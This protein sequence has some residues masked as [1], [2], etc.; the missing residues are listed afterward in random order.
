MAAI[1]GKG[2][3]QG[4]FEIRLYAERNGKCYVI[5]REA[6]QTIHAHFEIFPE[7]IQLLDVSFSKLQNTEKVN[8]RIENTPEESHRIQKICHLNN[9]PSPVVISFSA[10][11]ASIE[12]PNI[13]SCIN[14]RKSYNPR[15]IAIFPC[16]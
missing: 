3:D 16:L 14:Y 15:S 7:I 9:I 11:S 13:R 4:F 6:L 8:T 5:T 12:T 2:K 10:S 1:N